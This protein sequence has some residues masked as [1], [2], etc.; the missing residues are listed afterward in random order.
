MLFK[1]CIYWTN[2]DS[3]QAM[4]SEHK[5]A[6]YKGIMEYIRAED[7]HEATHGF[8]VTLHSTGLKHVTPLAR[9]FLKEICIGLFVKIIHQ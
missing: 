6:I 2:K 5:T 8:S 7:Y 1:S 3:T 4:L 9:G